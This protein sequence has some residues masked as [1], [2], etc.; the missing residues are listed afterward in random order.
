MTFRPGT[1]KKVVDVD[2]PHPRDMN[3][4]RFI[5]LQK[6]LTQMVMEEQMRYQKDEITFAT[7][8]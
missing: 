7:S 8:D 4:P 1:V 6:E 3:S 2:L 5:S